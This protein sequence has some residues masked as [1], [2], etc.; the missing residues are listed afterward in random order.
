MKKSK[1]QTASFKFLK[2]VVALIFGK[3]KFT[4]MENF[5]KEASIFVG[6]HT[7]IHGPIAMECFFPNPKMVW[8]ESRVIDK[9]EFYEYAMEDFWGHK[10]K[11]SKWFYKLLAKLITPLFTWLFRSAFTIPVYRDMRVRHTFRE[12]IEH[13]QNGTN[14][15]IF[16]EKHQPYNHIVNEFQD[17]FVDLATLYY[18]RTGTCLCFVPF[19]H[20]PALKQIVLGKPITFDPERPIEEERTRICSYLKDEITAL[21]KGLPAHT[22]TPYENIKKKNYPKSK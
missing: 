6:N 21:A 11:R 16:A 19:Y 17:G 14:I 22:V 2:L 3:R 4:G 7:Q 9:K 5:P 8:C 10:S 15:V 20:A 12:S 1:K 18:R 13:L